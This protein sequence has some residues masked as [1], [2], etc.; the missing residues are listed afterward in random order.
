MLFQTTHFLVFFIVVYFLFLVTQ[1]KV[2]IRNLVLVGASYYFYSVWDWKYIFLLLFITV[3]DFALGIV[4]EDSK[5]QKQRKLWL[6]ISVCSNLG[7]LC[8]FKYFNFFLENLKPALTFL[9]PGAEIQTLQ[10]A[11]PVGISFFTFESLSYIIDIYRG[12][13]K[14]VRDPIDYALFISYFP[15]L[16]AGPIIR[17]STFFPSIQK[18]SDVSMTDFWWGLHRFGLGV[19]K[20]VLISDQIASLGVDEVFKNPGLYSSFEL[21]LAAYGYTFQIFLDF[22]A[23]SDM[24]IGLSKAMGIYLPENF[25]APYLAKNMQDFWR[26]W[27]IS[28]STW[29]RDYLYISLGGSHKGAF[30]RYLNVFITMLLGGLWH[31]ANWTFVI[32]GAY[33]GFFIVLSQMINPKEVS[34]SSK[35]STIMKVFVTFHITVLGWIIF[36]AENL[37]HLQI[38]ITQLS[39]PSHW[40]LSYQLPP[41]YLVFLGLGA[42]VSFSAIPAFAQWTERKI[43]TT[44]WGLRHVAFLT[45]VVSLILIF[46][47]QFKPFIYFQ[48]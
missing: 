28:L 17:P 39:S 25:R 43:V 15:H 45:I 1:K 27:H 3:V 22:S 48:F 37:Q 34:S 46:E 7:L 41:F 31:G 21:L 38:L 32:W 11:L 6:W 8:Y 40:S 2:R 14:A 26:R 12:K 13:M 10:I 18:P 20:K 47:N 5:S 4:L 42:L 23:Y 36:R 16:V 19:F 24:A 29:L 35:I 9:P 33:H 30:R 44:Q